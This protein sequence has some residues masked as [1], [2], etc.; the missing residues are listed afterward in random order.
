MALGWLVTRVLVVAWLVGGEHFVVG[1]VTYYRTSLDQLGELHLAHTL[2]E[3]P[4]P[5]VILLWLPYVVLHAH[6][7]LDAYLGVVAGLAA[8]ADLLF[9][10]LLVRSGTWGAP[11]RRYAGVT[12]AEAVWLLAVPALGATCYARF[13][14]VPGIL[15]GLAVLL[16]VHRPGL[17]AAAGTLATGVKYWPALVLPALA[18]PRR[19]RRRVLRTALA[20]GAALSLASLALGGWSR[21]F[22]PLTY[23]DDRGL[24]IESVAATPAM[25]AWG[26]G[27]QGY[28]VGYTEWKAYDVTGPVVHAAL[29]VASISSV[30]VLAAIVCWWLLAWLRTERTDEQTEERTDGAEPVVWLVLAAVTGFMVTNKVLSPQYLL[31]LLPAAAAGLAVVDTPAGRRLLG[32]WSGGLLLAAVLTHEVF[33]RNYGYL[34]QHASETA[35]ITELLA[36]RNL[37]LVALFLTAA[38]RVTRLLWPGR[39][40]RDRLMRLLRAERPAPLSGSPIGRRPRSG[41]P[42]RP[43]RA[44][45]AE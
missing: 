10:I 39:A 43:D 1:D 41:R 17:A 44:G 13:D 21:L 33:P 3:Y 2:V 45:S 9:G 11:R 35:L 26:Q 16:M 6:G 27:E 12:A 23:Q 24:Q 32:W 42:T 40:E 18:A 4:V 25:L 29:R 5:G 28:Q 31:W 7:Q 14:V 22:T 19:G 8:L 37:I 36:A 38:W 15:V 30:V 20:L 34:V